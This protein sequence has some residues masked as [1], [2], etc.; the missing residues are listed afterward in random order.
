VAREVVRVA[1][2]AGDIIGQYETLATQRSRMNR[3]VICLRRPLFKRL[4]QGSCGHKNYARTLTQSPM[5]ID[6]M[7]FSWKLMKQQES[8]ES[9]VSS[10]Q[11][12]FDCTGRKMPRRHQEYCETQA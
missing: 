10:V 11:M 2:L 5:R 4:K 9:F 1:G 8:V 12:A 7:M 6:M 3:L